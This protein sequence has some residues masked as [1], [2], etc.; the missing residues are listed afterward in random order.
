MDTPTLARQQIFVLLFMM[1]GPF[2][3]VPTFAAL[4]ATLPKNAQ[5]PIARK[6]VLIAMIALMLGIEMSPCAV[7]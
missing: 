6:A 1:T 3:A 4:T 2:K 5:S 7:K